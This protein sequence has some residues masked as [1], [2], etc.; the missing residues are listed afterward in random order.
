MVNIDLPSSGIQQ[1]GRRTD[2][3]EPQPSDK[4]IDIHRL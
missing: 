3:S 2:V 1:I 4:Y